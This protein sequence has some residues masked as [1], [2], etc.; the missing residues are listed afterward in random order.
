M[1][2]TSVPLLDLRRL[3]ADLDAQLLAANLPRQRDRLDFF[4]CGPPPM[5]AGVTASLRDIGVAPQHIHTEKFD[6]V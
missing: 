5:V 1:T 3:S 4:I 2:V 6:F